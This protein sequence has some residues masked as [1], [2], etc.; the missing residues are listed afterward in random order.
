MTSV[1]VALS[2][3]SVPVM[4]TEPVTLPSVPELP[5]VM[6][7]ML[8][9]LEVNVVELVTLFPFNDAAKCTAVPAGLVARLIGVD[10]VEVIVRVVEVPVV[11]VMVPETTVPL[12]DCAAACTVTA[13][14]GVV[15]FVAVTRPFAFTVTKPGG[16]TLQ[17]A[18]PLRFLWLP[19][20]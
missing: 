4:V 20:S 8:E 9:L 3:E 18:V 19:S 1:P 17:V 5:D 10:G 13:V 7:M 2:A 12:E 15:T 16:V 14:P 11:I 6:L